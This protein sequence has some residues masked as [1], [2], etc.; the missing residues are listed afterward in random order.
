MRTQG[1][2]FW[3]QT[4]GKWNNR[5][6]TKYS[7]DCWGNHLWKVSQNWRVPAVTKI[8][9]F[10][11]QIPDL[12]LSAL[13]PQTADSPEEGLL[14]LEASGD[15]TTLS[16][17]FVTPECA[18]R[19]SSSLKSCTPIPTPLSD[20]IEPKP[21]HSAIINIFPNYTQTYWHSF[22]YFVTSSWEW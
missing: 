19:G 1:D 22:K 7:S 20:F 17:S 4:R 9:R 11:F 12:T 16:F 2:L 14:P 21:F 5:E 6:V 18:Y 8:R 13:A 3:V 10:I 15:S